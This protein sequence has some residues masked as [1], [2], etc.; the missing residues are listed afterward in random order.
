MVASAILM[1]HLTGR[2]NL[3]CKHCY[4]EGSPKRKERLPFEWIEQCLRDAPELGI[5]SL[6]LTG[7]E[8]IMYPR[9]R[10]VARIRCGS[11]WLV[12]DSVHERD[13]CAAS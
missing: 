1:L 9:F 7:G 3:E 11:G 4:M 12:Y 10:D 6:F 5:G 8:P 2:C 13:A